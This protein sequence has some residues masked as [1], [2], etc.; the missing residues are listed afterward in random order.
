MNTSKAQNAAKAYGKVGVQSGAYASPHRLIQ[1]LMDGVLDKISNAKGHMSRG[2]IK[3]KGNFI[4]WAIS[5][6][7]GLR[8]SLDFEKGGEIATNLE[9]LYD[10]MERSL[11]IANAE[12]DMEKLD[13]VSTLLTTIRDAWVQIGGAEGGEQLPDADQSPSSAG[14]IAGTV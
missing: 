12:N 5:I 8:A 2:D 7:G 13:E 6:I 1:M 11:V 9:S 14:N 3:Q 10:Y 4:S